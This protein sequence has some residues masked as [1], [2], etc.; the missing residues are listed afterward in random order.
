MT[1]NMI[2]VAASNLLLF[3]KDIPPET[4]LDFITFK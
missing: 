3:F 4:N 2:A 1:I